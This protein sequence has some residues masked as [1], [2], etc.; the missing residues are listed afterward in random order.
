MQ[1]TDRNK[2]D[3]IQEETGDLRALLSLLDNP[4]DAKL[5]RSGYER[6]SEALQQRATGR[7]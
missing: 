4:C 7:R 1:Q 6:L 3:R 2:E 5:V